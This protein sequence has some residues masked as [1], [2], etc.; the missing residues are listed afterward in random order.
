MLDSWAVVDPARHPF[1]RAGAPA[2]VR[3]LMPPLPTMDG[4]PGPGSGSGR[5]GSG[6]R[7]PDAGR[8]ADDWRGRM[9]AALVGHYGE[10]AGGWWWTGWIGAS[11]DGWY[12]NDPIV[13]DAARTADRVVTSLGA[14]RDRL[15]R[16]AVVIGR[17]GPQLG[18]DPAAWEAAATDVITAAFGGAGEADEWQGP[19]QRSLVW[20]LT[21]AGIPPRDSDD[22]AD[23]ALGRLYDSWVWPTAADVADIAG[24]FAAAVTGAPT[25]PAG[26]GA[27]AGEWPDTW[28]HSWPSWRATKV[29]RPIERRR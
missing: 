9:T 3:S 16:L 1:D 5:P 29:T 2:V 10:W 14:W 15:E 27:T 26:P 21:A 12:W 4:G 17:H 11:P 8:A 20:L 7:W 18:A 19:C 25:G 13:T 28:P 24:R 6:R 22:L 23:R